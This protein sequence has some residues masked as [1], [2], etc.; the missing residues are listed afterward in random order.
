MSES[1]TGKPASTEEIKRWEIPAIDGN[2]DNG[3][4]TAGRM[5]EL[6]KQAWEE[7]YEAGREEGIKAGD[8]E[9]R[10]RAERLD[11]LLV[12]IARPFDELDETVEKQLVELA[13]TVVKQLFRRELRID[14]THII[15]VVRDAIK[16][17]PAA[18]RDVQVHLHPEDA[19][20]VHESLSP[21]EGERAWKIVEDPLISKGGCK[22]STE[23][24]QIDAQA[25][26]RLQAIIS[27][28]AGDER[29][30]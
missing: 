23:N 8:E 30:S 5:Q 29:Q 6:Q 4:L 2:A 12:A 17:L 18:S 22:V 19:A 27:A 9:A 11:Q 14:P 26:T 7:A 16:L 21:S 10:A 24:S 13:M 20:L 28:I 15:G 3:F 1:D 25:E